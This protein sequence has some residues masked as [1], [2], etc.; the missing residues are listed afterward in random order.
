MNTA[1]LFH[2]IL[3]PFDFSE[4]SAAALDQAVTLARLTNAEIT[5]V[6]VMQRRSAA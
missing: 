5:A 3:V 2:K 4:G 6:H 1:T